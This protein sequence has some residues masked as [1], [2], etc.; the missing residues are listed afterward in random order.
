[1]SC[2]DSRRLFPAYWDDEITQAERE[3]LE[4]HFTSCAR[5]RTRYEEYARVMEAV[6][7]LPRVETAPDLVERTLA[8]A[9][10]AS[11]A[12]DVMPE[13]RT[14]WV[15]ATAAAALL[16]LAA[17]VLSQWAGL[18][19]HD[20]ERM[21]LSR[22]PAATALRE[23]VAARVPGHEAGTL[24]TPSTAVSGATASAGDSTK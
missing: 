15:P 13:R 11:A 5:C 9:R 4:A 23:P 12:R 17:A 20:S 8:R 21:A 6:S 19:G 2:H 24:A 22:N 7:T 18:R 16:L 14:A 1:M 10:R 3:W